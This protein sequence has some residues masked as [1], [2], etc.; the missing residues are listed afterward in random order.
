M[1][2]NR[3]TNE[4]RIGEIRQTTY[5]GVIRSHYFDRNPVYVR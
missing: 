4:E 2:K 5:L 3:W 1:E